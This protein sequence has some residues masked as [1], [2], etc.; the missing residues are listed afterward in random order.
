MLPHDPRLDELVRTGAPTTT[1]ATILRGGEAVLTNLSLSAAS[2]D[3]DENAASRYQ[4]RGSVFDA[5]GSLAPHLATDA[6]APYGSELYLESG[7]MLPT[8]EWLWVPAGVYRLRVSDADSRGVV[9]L[10]GLDRSLVVAN[11]RN[12]VPYVIPGGASLADA[13]RDYLTAKY[14]TV[15]MIV[16]GQA[17][18]VSLAN[19]PTVYEEG[20]ASG[21]PWMNLRD[22]TNRFGWETFFDATGAAILRP[23]PD[24]TQAE[25]V[26]EYVPGEANLSIDGTTTLD[27]STTYNVAVVTGEGTGVGS[28]VRASAEITDPSSPI[29]PGG[30][31]G[32]VPTFISSSFL[33]TEE[34]CQNA[35]DA[36]IRR[37]QGGDQN[38]QFSA[39]PHP[40]HEPGDVVR[41][42][43]ERATTRDVTLVLS[44]WRFNPNLRSET[45][46]RTRMVA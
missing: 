4:L 13:W 41:W 38:H 32:R 20:A 14:P 18:Y 16:D 21:D 25:V 7:M 35:A 42:R 31:Y 1:R 6:L 28:P 5:D 23:I 33:T 44:A 22:L 17:E 29:Y 10:T 45:P 19:S 8:G 3:V 26:W 46:Y 12:E 34:Q 27:P 30:T 15:T 36:M 39:V 9:T 11:A 43:T 2:V 40:A 37:V 24:Y